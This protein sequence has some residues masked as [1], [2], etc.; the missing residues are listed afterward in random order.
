MHSINH[1]VEIHA[2]PCPADTFFSLYKVLVFNGSFHSLIHLVT[3]A[4]FLVQ[5][6]CLISRQSE[7]G[8]RCW[9]FNIDKHIL[10]FLNFHLPCSGRPTAARRH[11]ATP[12]TCAPRRSWSKPASSTSSSPKAESWADSRFSANA[13]CQNFCANLKACRTLFVGVHVLF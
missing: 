4:Y 6:H 2:I 11:V 5:C 10:P 1:K 8:K 12:P 7:T 13:S 9:Y 3:I